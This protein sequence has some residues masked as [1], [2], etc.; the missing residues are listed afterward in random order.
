[1]TDTKT[2]ELT[3]A[4]NAPL[5]SVFAAIK[6]GMLFRATQVKTF[7]HEF[8]VGGAWSLVWEEEPAKGFGK[9]IEIVPERLIRFTWTSADHKSA[10]GRETLVT[11]TLSPTK[12]GCILKLVHE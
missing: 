2:I 8:R 3:K 9:Y 12:G 10:T 7:Q 1:M 4:I 5:S 6:D 11:V